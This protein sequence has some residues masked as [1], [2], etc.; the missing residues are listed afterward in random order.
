MNT[1]QMQE[2]N[3]RMFSSSS[4]SSSSCAEWLADGTRRVQV[5]STSK[6][7]ENRADRSEEQESDE[8]EESANTTTRRK[9]K[10]RKGDDRET[11]SDPELRLE[12]ERHVLTPDSTRSPSFPIHPFPITSAIPAAHVSWQTTVMP[13]TLIHAAIQI[14][15][16]Q[17]K[18]SVVSG[19]LIPEMGVES[20]HTK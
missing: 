11:S 15:F 6:E 20:M 16:V 18:I 17:L 12:H 14:L 19:S 5:Q 8:G 2:L 10:G 4:S 1:D 7:E 13:L 3:C 9:G